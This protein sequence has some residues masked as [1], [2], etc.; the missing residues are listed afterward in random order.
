MHFYE[1]SQQYKKKSEGESALWE[2]IPGPSPHFCTPGCKGHNNTTTYQPPKMF[3]QEN[4]KSAL[5][6]R[7]LIVGIESYD[8]YD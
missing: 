3:L 7:T 8:H 2:I 5:K 1:L 4:A 6:E